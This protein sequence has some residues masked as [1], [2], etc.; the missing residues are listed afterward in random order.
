[1]TWNAETIDELP[2]LRASDAACHYWPGILSQ[3][4][5]GVIDRQ[6]CLLL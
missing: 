6:V 5:T 2:V 4:I 3:N 1:M